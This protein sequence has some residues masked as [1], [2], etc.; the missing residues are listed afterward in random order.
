MYF[1]FALF[2]V[3]QVVQYSKRTKKEIM[4]TITISSILSL[5]TTLFSCV[6]VKCG[7]RPKYVCSNIMS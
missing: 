6:W 2:G 1:S 4:V 7:D 3:F 5:N